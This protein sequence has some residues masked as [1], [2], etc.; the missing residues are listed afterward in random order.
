MRKSV[1]VVTNTITKQA[2]VPQWE[3]VLLPSVMEF[4]SYS[5]LV[6][7]VYLFYSIVTYFTRSVRWQHILLTLLSTPAVE[8][9]KLL[10]TQLSTPMVMVLLF[11]ISS[12]LMIH[13]PVSMWQGNIT[14]TFFWN[15]I[16][17]S[18]RGMINENSVAIPCL[19]VYLAEVCMAI[20]HCMLTVQHYHV[21]MNIMN[22]KKWYG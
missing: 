8:K 10:S 4:A 12:T 1:S 16:E 18:E 2:F 13:G 15:N 5:W 9:L 7:V 20:N 22:D 14:Q 19:Y 6:I 21:N 17:L 3:N 11:Q